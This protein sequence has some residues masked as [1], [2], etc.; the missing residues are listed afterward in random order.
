MSLEYVEKFYN[1]YSRYYDL[2]FGRVSKGGRERAPELLELHPGAKLLEVGVGTGL[3]LPHMPKDIE[4]T[5][6]DM[7]QKMLDEAHKKVQSL[8]L[9][10]VK[11][12]KMDATNQEFEDNSFDRVL[13]AYVVSVVPDPLKLVAEMKR[14]CKPGG[15]LVFLNHFLSENLVVRTVEKIISPVCYRIGFKTNLHLH[16]LMEECGLEIE[17]LEPIDFLGNWKAVRCINKK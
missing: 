14:V 2:T 12:F 1:R 4:I 5:G 11:L 3:S 9:A 8:D 6:I 17:T 16:D 15:Y 13:A 10:H 7:S